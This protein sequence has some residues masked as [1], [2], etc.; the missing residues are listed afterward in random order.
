MLRRH[1]NQSPLPLRLYVCKPRG[2]V[3]PA[4]LLIRRLC[5]YEGHVEVRVV[6][7]R[8]FWPGDVRH[9]PAAEHL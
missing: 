6:L 7:S 1:L 2:P 8:L 5:G 9:R 3:I 4:I